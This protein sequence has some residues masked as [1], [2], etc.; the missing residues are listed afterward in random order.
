MAGVDSEFDGMAR[1]LPGAKIGYLPQEPSLDEFE[2]V[3]EAIN[4]AVQSSR[5]VLDQYNEL[6]L[7]L[8]DPDLSDSQMQETMDKIET[9]TNKIEAGNLWEL[10]R[11]VERAMDSLR[12]PPGD[13]TIRTLSGGRNDAQLCVSCCW[14]P[15]T[16]F[17][18]MNQLTTWMR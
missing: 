18:W 14:V 16:C 8:A 15:Q 11:V 7:K 4:Q 2:T 3:Q 9:L 5:D 1:P 10:D 17:F 6:S 13:A 12:V